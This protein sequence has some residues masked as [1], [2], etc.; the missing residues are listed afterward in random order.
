MKIG[1]GQKAA[2]VGSV[3]DLFFSLKS[4]L[5]GRFF[6][7][8]SIYFEVTKQHNPMESIEGIYKYVLKMLSP[9]AAENEAHIKSLSEIASNYIEAERLR[10]QSYILQDVAQ[11]KTPEEAEEKVKETLDKASGY[12]DTLVATET[13]TAQAFAEKDGIIQVAASLGIDDPIVYKTGVVDKKLCH[14]CKVLWH[15]DGNIWVPKVYRL[16]ELQDGYN[17]D[18]KNPIPTLNPTHP[19]CRHV[20]SMLPP[21]FGFDE[22]GTPRFIAF[23]HDEYVRQRKP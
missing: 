21:N 16:S 8:P 9:G 6:K 3:D 17:R 20:M 23:G 18:S 14:N 10:I 2:I 7:G 11:A 22:R 4:K 5:L 12:L 19:H 1:E 15:S 13:R